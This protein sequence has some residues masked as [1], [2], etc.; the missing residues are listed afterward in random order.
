[1]RCTEA[2]H[3]KCLSA[4]DQAEI[5]RSARLREKQG[6]TMEDSFS[7]SAPPERQM[8][9]FD[10]MTD[11]VCAACNQGG[12]CIECHRDLKMDA[13]AI[14]GQDPKDSNVTATSA[15]APG[16]LVVSAESV[17]QGP[18]EL[19]FR[20]V[21]CLR[22]AHYAH[23]K[24]PW[25]EENAD[26]PG[27]IEAVATH[28]QNQ[29]SWQCDDCSSYTGSSVD[30]ILAW[31]PY[32]ANAP[33]FTPEE[34][35]SKRFKDPWPREYLVKWADKSYRRTSWVPHLWLVSTAYQKLRHFIL[36]GTRVRLEHLRS[37]GTVGEENGGPVGHDAEEIAR[38]RVYEEE[39]GSPL[40]NPRAEE[41]IPEPWKRI[42]QVLDVVLWA[43]HKRMKKIKDKQTK[44]GSKKSTIVHSSG[45]ET[46]EEDMDA[47]EMK[48][49][50]ALRDR[51]RVTGT[52]LLAADCIETPLAR[53]RRS[54]GK[55][56]EMVDIDDVVWCYAK[57]GE[58]EYQE[59][60]RY[61]YRALIHRKFTLL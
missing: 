47:E 13:R 40:P 52:Q 8:I 15:E 28:Y 12:V 34:V 49:L 61:L 59:G 30:K 21:T 1:M 43:P 60:K 20:C 56:L 18:T 22:A 29:Y 23:L 27:L 14:A 17:S 48:K 24:S 25:T 26:E 54:G 42:E 44:K 16:P 6:N 57:W 3:W 38:R 46:E 55:S 31:R 32:P 39:G 4:V 5:L 50:E 10:E 19:R 2:V 45:S 36:N 58:L 9:N 53:K 51:S 41:C 35:T 33:T 37:V 7:G 11:Y